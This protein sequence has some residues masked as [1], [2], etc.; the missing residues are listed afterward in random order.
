MFASFCWLC[1]LT[2]AMIR[3]EIVFFTGYESSWYPSWWEGLSDT[4]IKLHLGAI[5]TGAGTIFNMGKQLT[6]KG[7]S[8]ANF[9][10]C[11]TSV[12]KE[13]KL[14][15]PWGS[16]S[17]SWRTHISTSNGLNPQRAADK[18][19]SFPRKPN[20]CSSLLPLVAWLIC[21]CARGSQQVR[22]RK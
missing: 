1:I 22:D 10:W 18:V 16:S 7:R 4:V 15:P 17:A 6:H 8:G 19:F 5:C 3:H 20:H 14:R 9:E 11:V 21:S 13:E 2:Q 12:S